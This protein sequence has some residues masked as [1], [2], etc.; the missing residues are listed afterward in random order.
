MKEYDYTRTTNGSGITECERAQVLGVATQR[1]RQKRR[2][3]IT[4]HD[5]SSVHLKDDTGSLR[6]NMLLRLQA[7]AIRD[8]IPKHKRCCSYREDTTQAQRHKL[9]H[10]TTGTATTSRTQ[11]APPPENHLILPLIP[12]THQSLAA[13]VSY[14][15]RLE[16]DVV[17]LIDIS[18]WRSG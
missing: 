14:E 12:P 3:D 2:F 4:R 9:P 17:R 10:Q 6:S 15:S 11:S 8:E 13:S 18:K 5:R 1:V 7:S 16:T